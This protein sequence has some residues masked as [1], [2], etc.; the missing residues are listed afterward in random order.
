M[1]S[2]IQNHTL[3]K[4]IIE[5]QNGNKN[6]ILDDEQLEMLRRFVQDPSQ[7]NEILKEAGLEDRKYSP[8]EYIGGLS[9]FIV[10][11]HGQDH[12]EDV[13]NAEEIEM[14]RKWFE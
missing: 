12:S 10:L 4:A 6:L 14:L 7:R 11:R 2:L 13:L 3:A 1:N 5:S 9:Q 8:G